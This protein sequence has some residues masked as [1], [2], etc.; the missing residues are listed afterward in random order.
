MSF[1]Q[2]PHSELEIFKNLPDIKVVFDVGSRDDVDYLQ[3]RPDIELHAFEPNLEFFNLLKSKTEGMQNVHLNNYGLGD[4]ETVLP[5]DKWRQAF[6]GGAITSV[7]DGEPLP[8]KTL[9]WYV[10]ENNIERIDFLKI[11]TEGYDLKVIQGGWHA[12]RKTH[13]LQ[14]EHWDDIRP[15]HNILEQEFYMTYIGGRNVLCTRKQWPQ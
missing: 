5:Y 14:Y 2:I 6:T 7:H 1:D 8:I 10:K 15:F 3:L 12:I 11:D 9:D 13:Y 4:T